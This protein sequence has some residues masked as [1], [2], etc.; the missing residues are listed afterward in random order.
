MRLH[1][2]I[3][4]QHKLILLI[5]LLMILYGDY[6]P[7]C[8]LVNKG[9]LNDHFGD[10]YNPF[11]KC[12]PVNLNISPAGENSN[13]SHAHGID[14]LDYEPYYDLK[15]DYGWNSLYKLIDTLNN[16]S[17]SVESILNVD[18]TLWMHVLNYTLI[19]F[20]SYIGYG[21][22]IIIFIKIWLSSSI[23]SFGI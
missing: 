19:N 1:Q 23:L 22:I 18:R 14:S 8:K 15:S 20:D 13:L 12:N 5:S 6:I 10:K 17:N 2:I 11:F 9:F 7:M 3:C 4:L 16:Y 21:Q